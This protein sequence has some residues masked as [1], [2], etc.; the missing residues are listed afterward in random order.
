[1][2]E[3]RGLNAYIIPD[4]PGLPLPR[5]DEPRAALVQGRFPSE[6]I[7][8]WSLDPTDDWPVARSSLLHY[9]QSR[10][11]SLRPWTIAAIASVFECKVPR[12][13]Q[14]LASGWYWLPS[15]GHEQPVEAFDQGYLHQLQWEGVKNGNLKKV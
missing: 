5:I 14:Q 13:L 11:A 7:F 2:P 4:N 3:R 1:M 15:E 10:P 8:K 9:W 6:H 12:G